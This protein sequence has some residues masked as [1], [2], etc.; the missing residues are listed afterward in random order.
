MKR[1]PIRE[2]LL[3]KVALVAV[4]SALTIPARAQFMQVYGKSGYL[5]EYELSSIV[6][7]QVA[8]GKKEYSGP[9]A[10]K[11]VGL[12]TRDGPKKRPVKLDSG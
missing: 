9:L 10:V 7:E 6:F 5:G 12:C 11:H 8:S 2:V 4:L 3:R 1:R